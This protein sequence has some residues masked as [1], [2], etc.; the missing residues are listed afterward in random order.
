MT[1]VAELQGRVCLVTGTTAGIGFVTAA[2]L[3]R[4]GADVFVA[5]RPGPRADAA[6]ARLRAAA[7]GARIEAL[8]LDLGELASVRAAAE[9][10]LAR[11][12]PLHLLV[13]NA[14]IAGTRGLTKDGFERT[15]GVNHL[16]PF[17]LTT[18]LLDRLR[19]SAPARVVTVA[20]RAH[21]RVQGIDFEAVRKPTRSRTG[22]AEY[23]ASK[24]CNVLFSRELARRLA[25][26]G[27]TTYAL[28][29]GVVATEIWRRLPGPVQWLL[30]RFMIS[31]EE[32]ARTTLWCATAP[33]LASETGRY[34]SWTPQGPRPATPTAVAQDDALAAR[35][36][37]AS[38]RFVREAGA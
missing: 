19:A 36:W 28:H 22:F 38:E 15:F 35:L 4:R 12:L 7:P 33:E 8:A 37:D 6:L 17:L 26:T 1:P 29:P 3:A 5:N 31:V 27:V 9:A 21:Q 11:G 34:Y 24:L 2:E 30:R 10:F 13:N 25:G 16:G 20:S 23:G 18:L 14:G 32:G